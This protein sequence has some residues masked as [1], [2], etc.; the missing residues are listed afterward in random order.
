MRN[1]SHK[2]RSRAVSPFALGNSQISGPLLSLFSFN[3]RANSLF[4]YQENARYY[5]FIARN[6]MMDVFQST[7]ALIRSTPDISAISQHAA[8]NNS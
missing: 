1:R 7:P 3:L 4:H 2:G 8:D 5:F 6:I